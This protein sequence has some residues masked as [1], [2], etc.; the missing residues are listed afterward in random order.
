[1]SGTTY[2]TF[3][4]LAIAAI[5]LGIWYFFSTSTTTSI[6]EDL[7]LYNDLGDRIES[8]FNQYLLLTF[9]DDYTLTDTLKDGIEITYGNNTPSTTLESEDLAQSLSLQFPKTLEEP[10][11]VTLSGSRT[12]L[13]QQE[14]N[15]DASVSLLTNSPA[16]VPQGE[17]TTWAS[18]PERP[19]SEEA[20]AG[21]QSA[22]YLKYTT[23]DAR[24]NTY[25]AYQKDQ[26]NGYRNL[27]HW[28]I[29]TD[30]DGEE[31][32]SYRFSNAHLRLT[33]SGTVEVRYIQPQDESIKA[34]VGDDLWARAQAVL[35]ED[36]V[37]NI[38]HTEPDLIIPAPYTIDTNGAQ[39]T[40]DWVVT[41]AD[42][43]NPS[44]TSG[45]FILSTKFEVPLLSYPI[46]LDPT[47]QFTAPGYTEAG[48]VITG[49]NTSDNFGWSFAVGD[50]NADGKDDLAVGAD[51]YSTNTGRVY[52]FYGGSMTTEN[53]S[54]ADVT[55]TGETTSNFGYSLT[56]GDWNADGTDDLAVGATGYSGSTGRVYLF[57]GGSMTSESASGADVTLT[58]ETTSNNFGSSLTTG[59]FNADGTDDL[60]VGARGYSS[61]KGRVYLFYGGSMTTENASGADVTLTGETTSNFFG[62]SLTTGDFNAD[63]TDDL[64]VGAFGYSTYTGRVYLF[65]GGSM[66]SENA[67][68]AD[69]AL[70]GETTSSSFGY[71]LTTGDFNADGKDDLAVGARAYSS[72]T[73]RAYI[74]YSQSGQ[75]NLD[76]HITG[77]TTSNYFGYSLQTGDFNADGKDD[78]AVGA[79]GYNSIQG[80]A[81]IFYG[82]SMTSENAS[83]ADI[84]LT[85]E[86]SS[87]YFG[88]SLQTGDFNAD[89]KDD[90]AVGAWGYSTF[91]G[92]AYIFYGGSMISENASG[93]DVT[94]TGEA[95][96]SFLGISLQT[97][98][99]NADGKDDLAVGA[100]VYSSSIGRAY[101]F[102]GG[103]IIT[104]NASG[105]DVILTGET[106][107]NRFGAALQTGDFNADGKDDLAVGAWGY[108]SDQGR[109]Y[110][111]YGGSMTSENASGADVIMTGETTSNLFGKSIITGD[112]NADGKD[113]LAVGAQQYS[114]NTGRV[115]IFYGGSMVSENAT[116]A[117]VILT[118]DVANDDYGT[119]LATYDYNHDGRDDLVV[120][121]PGYNNG[122]DTGRIYFYETRENYVWEIQ[123]QSLV[124]GVRVHPIMGHEMKITGESGSGQFG[125][126]MAVG[127]F[128]ADGK[129][130]LAVGANEFNSGQGRV[131]IFYND[132]NY[133]TKASRADVVIT[134]EATSN[135]FGSVLETGDFNADGK[136]D[137]AVGAQQYSSNTGRVYIFYGGSIVTENAVSANV[138][139]TGGA[140]SNYFGNTLQTGDFN[141]DGK[142]DLAVGAWGYSASTGRT[143]LFYGGSM[144]SESASGADVTLTGGGTNNAMG[145]ALQ[146]GDFNA[147]GKDDLAVGAWGYS[148]LTGRAYIFYGGSM[149][150]EN[151]SGAD[152][153]L[154]GA[155]IINFFGYS[156]QTGDFNADGKDDL[157][158]GAYGYNSNQGRTYLFYG[159]SMISESATG[160]DVA[161]TGD[162]TSSGF[163]DSLQTGDFNHDGKD[164]LVV[165]TA[166][167]NSNQGRAYIFYGGS[168]TSENASGADVIMTGETTSNLFGKSIIT[169][170]F[171]ADGKDDLAVGAWGVNSNQ[172]R[173]YFYTT[174][175][176]QISG[177]TANEGIGTTLTTG[178]FN[179]DGKLDLAVGAPVYSSNLGRL[180][181]FYGG[182]NLSETVATA[183]YTITGESG[184][185]SFGSAVAVG[186]LNSDG[187]DD[188]LVGAHD[189]GSDG[190]AYIYYGGGAFPSAAASAD[191]VITGEVSGQHFGFSVAVADVDGDGDDDAI[192]SDPYYGALSTGKI[193]FYYNDGAYPSAAGS[194]D[195]TILGTNFAYIGGN[196]TCADLDN[197]A[198]NDLL[199][200]SITYGGGAYLFYNSAGFA[201]VSSAA[202]A[203]FA[204]SIAAD[205]EVADFD[206]DANL[207][208][209]ISDS[210]DKKVRVYF[211]AVS[212][213]GAVTPD[214]VISSVDSSFGA[215]TT[216][217]DLNHDGKDDLVISDSTNSKSDIL[218]SSSLATGL[219]DDL[220]DLMVPVSGALLIADID[221]NGTDDLLIGDAGYDVSSNEGR[222]YVIISEIAAVRYS[223]HKI[224]GTMKIQGSGTFH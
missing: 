11:A 33:D 202:D 222:V 215:Y 22:Q 87:N 200:A 106:N 167:Y 15:T 156:L 103:S 193:Y 162:G 64:A 171:N 25:Y 50:F 223:Q 35:A 2:R 110:I 163:G 130:D 59:D 101:L 31:S 69:I 45:D 141:A 93:A 49:E 142:D 115:Y 53:A 206:G 1:M 161:L 19:L 219:A 174:N 23:P 217:G 176:F 154:T 28:T 114:S 70:T 135:Q 48:S 54:G 179:A 39:T 84:I 196:L 175:D 94:L 61:S 143:Y 118:G 188:L 55:L 126:S 105:A 160:A 76:T 107:A 14:D 137:L 67:S 136:D 177:V 125:T 63:G 18:A 80:R 210:F 46:A 129:D 104:E 224:Q 34:Q 122:G 81:Y 164:D 183:D 168:M 74:F 12:I 117:D 120:G 99:F 37:A 86:T 212:Y 201:T 100:S 92:R 140:T 207:D 36:L 13:V 209:V 134:G 91:T 216:V 197:D 116:G 144:I 148:T 184:V 123:R 214:S 108:N 178:D 60:A 158:V 38:E 203:T 88:V 9:T 96:F 211:D 85:G 24:I 89:G 155:A 95:T 220:S 43:I 185:A 187:I 78:L 68:G 82:G 17:G 204:A 180:Y 109:A 27:K 124:D 41:P 199:A 145:A 169:G 8:D 97:G 151:A 192:I 42:A 133:E 72:N 75:V 113:D 20:S 128:N 65:Y 3:G 191:V 111:F 221:D 208:F 112:F 131:Y 173:V 213:S 71:A 195:A 5:F 127:D 51:G 21:E 102:Y 153:T 159:G 152:I 32:Q 73:G 190:K 58:G 149:I 165:G 147:D 132:G 170:D 150:S 218:Y 7:A 194:A 98:D 172:G 62:Y 182:D 205:I 40:H 157:A 79:Y 26:A 47:L 6:T 138:I 121:A 139:L 83:G 52:L 29:F 146:T 189:Q 166:G 186:D 16:E 4:V 77:E 198:D 30:G 44:D 119:S 10:I 90:L 181:I 57:Y 56:T 66:T